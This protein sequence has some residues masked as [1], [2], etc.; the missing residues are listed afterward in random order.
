MLGLSEE[1]L[2]A[3]NRLGITTPT[4]IQQKAIPTLLGESCDFLGLAQ[5]GT[6]KT[7]AYGLPLIEKIEPGKKEVQALIITPTRELG[8]QVAEQLLAFSK[9]KKNIFV[10]V[11]YGGKPIDKQIYFLRKKPQ[12]VVATP[13]RL[14]DLIR[15]NAIS[16]ST[17]RHVV[18]D[19]ADE[20]LNMGFQEDIDE[21]LSL[22]PTYKKVW[23]FSATMPAEIRRIA[24]TYMQDYKEVRVKSEEIVNANISHQVLRVK[25]KQ[26]LEALLRIINE[27]EISN[28]VIF[29]KTRLDTQDLSDELYQAGFR[30]DAIHGD[31]SQNQRDRVMQRFK[32]GKMQFLVATDVAARGIDVKNLSHVIHFTLPQEMEYYTHRS[33]RTG[34]AGNLGQSIAI[35]TGSESSR[36]AMFSQKLGIKFETSPLQEHFAFD[37]MYSDRS[38]SGGSGGRGRNNRNRPSSFGSSDRPQRRDRA[39]QSR[40]GGFERRENS[41]DAFPRRDR[42]RS[43]DD[44]GR[45]DRGRDDRGREN[46]SRDERGPRSGGGYGAPK[47]NG[48]KPSDQGDRFSS[49]ERKK[50]FDGEK[51]VS[52]AGSSYDKKPKSPSTDNPSSEGNKY[53]KK[54]F[55]LNEY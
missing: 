36:L 40:E 32:S 6:G 3:L 24:Q 13:G 39:P 49:G 53:R 5:T 37:E 1:T 14:L 34:R 30:A 26:K 4:E 27:Q 31:L 21:I 16:L 35:I 55:V 12:I 45:D 7:A 48:F 42:E 47:S 38:R 8:Q 28:A 19:E 20:M 22:T 10:E 54:A 25:P 11:V 43:R 44:R 41:F 50:K 51:K 46:R 9:F 23:L 2:E 52:F 17:I 15:R 33:G 18:L 29:C